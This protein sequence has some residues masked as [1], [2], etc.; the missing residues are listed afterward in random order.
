MLAAWTVCFAAMAGCSAQ[1]SSDGEASHY[2]S[3]PAEMAAPATVASSADNATAGSAALPANPEVRKEGRRIVYR[4]EVEIIVERF[5]PLPDQIAALVKKFGGFVSASNLVGSPGSHRTGRWTV[6]I[7]VDQ[8]QSV[9]AAIRQ[10]GEVRSINCTSDDVTAEYFDVES[11]IRNKKQEEDRLL[12]LLAEATGKLEE[13]LAVEK[14]LSR[15]RGEIEQAQGRL[16][17]MKD[18]TELT[19]VTITATEIKNYVPEQSPT[20]RT[21]I[22]RAWSASIANCF[23]FLQAASICAVACIPWMGILLVVIFVFIGI[24]RLRRR[25]Q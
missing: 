21:R 10:L 25:R 23:R 5:D 3:K 19:T 14:E 1:S 9:L 11:R 24:R 12:K 6:R 2:L 8:F 15:V 4:A 13:V 20:Y 22:K 18:L 16:R 7:P 17:V